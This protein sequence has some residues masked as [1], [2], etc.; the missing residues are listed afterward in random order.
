MPTYIVVPT[1][2]GPG[3]ILQ[4]TI[5]VADGD[6]YIIDPTVTASITFNAPVSSPTLNYEIQINE[7]NTGATGDRLIT[8]G[9]NTSPDVQIAAGVDASRYNFTGTTVD[10]AS[11]TV[12]DG[13]TT[14]NLRLG[15]GGDGGTNTVTLGIDV[16][17]D[18]TIT[19]GAGN[20]VITAGTNTIVNGAM[21]FGSGALTGTFGAGLSA[22][23]ISA[24]GDGVKDLTFG[25]DTTLSSGGT[26]LNIATTGTGNTATVVFG[27]NL[28]SAGGL[29]VNGT[30]GDNS[31]TVGDFSTVNGSTTANA[32]G[33]NNSV[34]FGDNGSVGSIFANGAGSSGGN[35]QNLVDIGTGTTTSDIYV[36]GAFSDNTVNVDAGST[37]NNIFFGTDGAVDAGAAGGGQVLSLA[38]GATTGILYLNSANSTYDIDFGDNVNTEFVYANG[39]NSDHT[40]DIGQAWT[41]DGSVFLGASQGTTNIN[42]L[43]DATVTGSFEISGDDATAVIGDRL[44][45]G[46]STI[47]G[48]L[49]G[50]TDITL[51]IDAN[52]DGFTTMY[53]DQ[54]DFTAGSGLTTGSGA[55]IGESDG[56]T[57]LQFGDNTTFGGTFD[58]NGDTFTMTTGTNFST[59]AAAYTGAFGSTSNSTTFGPG[60][61]IGGLLDVS[62]DNV[63]FDAGAGLT[64]LGIAY[65]GNTDGTATTATIGE[66]STLGGIDVGGNSLNFTGGA[67]LQ[68]NGTAYFDDTGSTSIIS[69]AD[70]T[71]ITGFTDFAAAGSDVT[72]TIGNDVT[73]GAGVNIDAGSGG[74]TNITAGDNFTFGN[75]I[76]AG[77]NSTISIG[78]GWVSTLNNMSFG[79]GDDT[80]TLGVTGE[81]GGPLNTIY[82]GE[83]AGDNDILTMTFAGPTEQA[84]FVSAALAA[85][86]TLN[87]DGSLNSQ[88]ATGA[89][90]PLTWNNFFI[91]EWEGVNVVCFGAGTRI[92]TG[93]GEVPVEQ[94]EI[95]SEVLTMDRGYQPIRW[96]GSQLLTAED[97][98]ACPNLRPIRIR[99]GTLGPN[100]PERD[101][102]VSPQHRVLIRSKLVSRMFGAKEILVAAKQLL[103]IEGVEIAEDLTEVCYFHFVFETHE[104]VFSNGAPTESLFTG[105]E[106]LKALSPEARDEIMMIFPELGSLTTERLVPARPLAPGRKA[107]RLVER[108][109]KNKRPLVEENLQCA[110]PLRA[111][112]S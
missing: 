53:G 50:I 20:D 69:I 45:I 73:L 76:G 11:Y 92:R 56:T 95:G 15:D 106:A 5:T 57:D 14:G 103:G 47:L 104:V 10:S 41:A 108:I 29:T 111:E 63:T 62:G 52:I 21:N 85:G 107:R 68:V 101:L 44:D 28:N 77:E 83:N 64:T 31:L 13:A 99:A 4:G 55:L 9:N 19:G 89:N 84:S 78:D 17:V 72:L 97:L 34:F 46:L 23:S 27:N 33:V 3:Q 18:G 12:G 70:G 1:I 49:N 96:I 67:N 39:F 61:N 51:G 48:D 6:I 87:P 43:N 82:G 80:V 98:S 75:L 30:G 105:P 112:S 40:I 93:D 35:V 60:A 81:T 102:I 32:G 37:T 25:N 26:S 74:T 7:T 24:S 86:W 22:T 94:L 42:I 16:T 91:S 8:L 54:L 79:T 36:N 58:A 66:N 88:S 2:T 65:I 71:N 109:I 110:P 59:S 100:Q 38:N 90:L